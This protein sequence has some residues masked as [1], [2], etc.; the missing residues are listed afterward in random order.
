MENDNFGLIKVESSIVSAGNQLLKLQSSCL[1][2]YYSELRIWWNGLNDEW[3]S[4]L[5][6]Y[7]IDD[8]DV[9]HELKAQGKIFNRNRSNPQNSDWEVIIDETGRITREPFD[10]ELEKIALL[11]HLSISEGHDDLRPVC[12]LL[13]LESIGGNLNRG[14]RSL[15]GIE[16]LTHLK[17]IELPYSRIRDLEPLRNVIEIECLNFHDSKIEKLNPLSHL[18]EL[19]SLN[20]GK[21]THLSDLT[22][23]SD[24]Y[25]LVDLDCSS[26]SDIDRRIDFSPIGRLVKL[27]KLN[28]QGNFIETLDFLQD[29]KMLE[30]LN[31]EES[32]FSDNSL[33][34]LSDLRKLK[35]LRLSNTNVKNLTPLLGL[36]SLKYLWVDKTKIPDYKVK[37]FSMANPICT[38][39]IKDDTFNDGTCVFYKDA[40][41]RHERLYLE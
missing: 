35:T 28:C 26:N 13:N 5:I 19:R 15:I 36:P 20:I 41:L 6:Y 39:I 31:L 29:L 7:F 12:K 9:P 27:E 17:A 4:D 18:Q 21:A 16:T 32:Y 24:L 11:R 23:L 10:F 25:E 8:E 33:A 34:P 22:A 37:E 40:K 1:A 2:N 14:L 38:V 3:K 30:S